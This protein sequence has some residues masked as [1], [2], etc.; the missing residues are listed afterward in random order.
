M[1][2]IQSYRRSRELASCALAKRALRA[3]CP[4]RAAGS[5]VRA[6]EQLACFVRRSRAPACAS[7]S[8]HEAYSENRDFRD[9]RAQAK[10]AREARET[11]RALQSARENGYQLARLT[12]LA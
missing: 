12:E 9:F 5:G 7:P 2:A 1:L 4:L 8:A 10:L 6:R 11:A 3:R